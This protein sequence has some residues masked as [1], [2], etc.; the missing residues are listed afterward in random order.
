MGLDMYAYTIK[1]EIIGD[2]QVDINVNTA[3]EKYLE[4]DPS[5]V[6]EVDSPYFAEDVAVDRGLFDRHFSY[7]RK[8][9]A[10]HGWMQRLY[11]KKGGTSIDFNC[12]TLRLMPEDLDLLTDETDDLEPVQGFFFGSYEDIT[13]EEKDDIAD[14]VAKAHRAIREGKAVIY[15]SW[16]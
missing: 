8:F 4:K 9:N 10:L 15:T 13:Q 14:F 2:A 11:Y 1:A 5:Y 12:D 7:W 16:W 3:L 6:K